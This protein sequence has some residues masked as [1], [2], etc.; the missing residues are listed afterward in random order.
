MLPD[1]TRI[2]DEYAKEIYTAFAAWVSW[3]KKHYPIWKPFDLL[4]FIKGASNDSC[5]ANARWIGN[6]FQVGYSLDLRS[7]EAEAWIKKYAAQ[8]IKYIDASSKKAIR[9]IIS[10]SFEEGLTYQ[11]QA[12]QIAPYVGLDPRR[13]Q[14]LATY[15]TNLGLEDEQAILRLTE[16]YGKRLIRDRATTIALTESHIA[17]NQGYVDSTAEAVKRNIIDPAIYEYEWVLTHDKRTCPYCMAHLGD[18]A[19]IPYGT[20]ANGDEPG[21]I[22]PRD[23]CC[24]R[25]VRK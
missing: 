21:T 2:G 16:N 14:A 3:E 18:R 1:T 23:R 17:S 7:P 24:R 10:K 20:F 15:S 8:E 6:K 19:E 4:K 13:A 25:I 22:H 9:D 5:D 12:K 11:Q